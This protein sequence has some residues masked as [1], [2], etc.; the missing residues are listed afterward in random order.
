[1]ARSSDG[2]IFRGNAQPRYRAA[3]N[4]GGIQSVSNK[5]ELLGFID[6]CIVDEAH[7]ISHKAEGGY[8]Q[9][10]ESLQQKNPNMRVVGLTATPYRLGHGLISE[11]GALFDALIEPVKVEEL[12]AR[13]FLAPLRSKFPQTTLSVDGVG[14]RGGE[15]IESVSTNAPA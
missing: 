14:K 3:D 15:F 10:I 4:S 8:R 6:I 7:L 5:A 2:D 13:G 11:H 9:L 1:M 12:V